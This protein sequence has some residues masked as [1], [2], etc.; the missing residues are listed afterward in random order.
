MTKKKLDV[1]KRIM[2]ESGQKIIPENRVS[3]KD[4][5]YAIYFAGIASVIIVLL[6]MLQLDDRYLIPTWF[7]RYL[8]YSFTMFFPVVVLTLFGLLT[9]IGVQSDYGFIIISF[10]LH[11]T[12]LFILAR[13]YLRKSASERK[14]YVLLLLLGLVIYIIAAM[15]Y[16]M[17]Y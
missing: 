13:V 2:Q 7:L 17:A 16:L 8:T 9:G 5:R 14:K 3:K 6:T 15:R 10:L 4:I 1:K 11:F 12:V